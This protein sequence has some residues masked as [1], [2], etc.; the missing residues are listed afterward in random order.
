VV[1]TL[2]N[3]A[4]VEVGLPDLAVRGV[5]AH[6]ETAKFDLSLDLVELSDGLVGSLGYST[7]LWDD[8]TARRMV[9]HLA[10]LL[11][12]VATAP[13]RRLSRLT[14][15]DDEERRLLVDEWNRT[16]TAFPRDAC[17]HELFD[18]Q[19]A[20]RPNAVA[21][22]WGDARLTYRGLAE[23][24]NRLANHL[25]RHGVGPESRVGVL[26]ERGMEMIVSI[27]AVLKAGGCYVPLDPAYPAE[28]LALMLG[29]AGVRVLLSRGEQGDAISLPGLHVVA[30]D[31]AGDEVAA[32]SA[33]APRSGAT[34]LNLAYI[35]YTS[36]ST[37]RPKGVMVGHR[38]VVQLVRETDF[39]QLRPGDRVA[40]ASNASF[41][42]LAFEAWGA[43]LNGATLVGIPRETLLSPP[44]LRETLRAERITT[45][46]QTTALLNQLTREQGDVFASLREVL[47]GGQAADADRVRR[48]LGNGRPRRLLHVYGPT[49]TTAW[50][51]YEQVEHV[52]EGAL[53]VSV[54]RPIA[55]ARI[56]VL[57]AGLNA[58][59]VGVPGE[60]YVGGAGVVRG[61]L[62][63]PAL[64]A[65][66]F[67]PDPFAGEPGAR[68]YRTGDRVRW[69]ADGTLEFV[70]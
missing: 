66:R 16:A 55:N 41:D 34:P 24:A 40:Q 21:L 58:V 44:A 42:A 4:P 5:G 23:R 52:P 50:C 64:T 6:L 48:L 12:Q 15:T 7:D 54:G 43:F 35:V 69:R 8:A 67:V 59:P 18:A 30:L 37:G 38:E 13:D 29:D 57:D 20:E 25:V 31:R 28:R 17:I 60:A 56:Y 45:L 26:M 49:E 62:D 65:E 70:G 19:V 11:E 51:T 53:T 47:F 36:G 3:A 2:Q 46:Y 63:R 1:F 27:L 61:Y 68:M 33:E 10:R 22:A 39:V 32:E 14:L 9:E